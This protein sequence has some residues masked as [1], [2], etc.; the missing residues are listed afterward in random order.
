MPKVT[1][2][3]FSVDAT[4]V[5]GGVL[6]FQKRPGG[7]AVYNFAKPGSRVKKHGEPTAAQVSIRAYVWDAVSHWKALTD[8]QKQ[9]WNDYFVPK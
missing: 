5:L 1:G 3:L 2:P 9:S 6:T 8:E 4:G 7:H